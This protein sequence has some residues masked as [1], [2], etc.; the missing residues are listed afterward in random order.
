[1]K[2]PKFLAF[3]KNPLDLYEQLRGERLQRDSY[4]FAV[5][6]LLSAGG[7]VHGFI[8]T[9]ST[10]LSSTDYFLHAYQAAHALKTGSTDYVDTSQ[11]ALY[12]VSVFFVGEMCGALVMS[13][14]ADTFGRRATLL[15]S[16]LA[17]LLLSTWYVLAS[18]ATMVMAKFCLGLATGA[19]V[20]TAVVYVA[21]IAPCT[22]RG[23]LLALL[24]LQM[25]LGTLLATLLHGALIHELL[26]PWISATVFEALWRSAT[27]VLLV[28][29]LAVQSAMLCF[30]PE[31]PRW[32]LAKKTP[33][34]TVPPPC[35]ARLRR[36]HAAPLPRCATACSASLQHY[37][38]LPDVKK[39]FT[40]MYRALSS[41]ARLGDSLVELVVSRSVKL[42]WCLG[43]GL[44]LLGPALGV[45]L[46]TWLFAQEVLASVG[47]SVAVVQL[48]LLAL[49]ACRCAVAAFAVG[50]FDGAASSA[51]PPTSSTSAAQLQRSP[52]DVELRVRRPADNAAADEASDEGAAVDVGDAVVCARLRAAGDAAARA[53]RS[54]AGVV[55]GSCAPWLRWRPG[56]RSNLLAGLLLLAGGLAALFLALVLPDAAAGHP[57]R[58]TRPPPA[59]RVAAATVVVTA[60]DALRWSRRLEAAAALRPLALRNGSVAADPDDD[61]DDGDA[62]A[63]GGAADGTVAPPPPPPV[64][65]ED[66]DGYNGDD[67]DGG[68]GSLVASDAA[69]LFLPST[70]IRLLF[71]AALLSVAAGGALS[72]ASV[73]WVFSGDVFPYRARAKCTAVTSA[74]HFG[75]TALALQLWRRGLLLGVVPRGVAAPLRA[76]LRPDGWLAS[77]RALSLATAA[78]FVAALCAAAAAF[79]LVPE[80]AALM[81]EDMEALFRVDPRGVCCGCC[82]R[83]DAAAAPLGLCGLCGGPPR[84]PRARTA[85]SWWRALFAHPFSDPVAAYAAAATD[86]AALRTAEAEPQGWLGLRRVPPHIFARSTTTLRYALDPSPAADGAATVAVAAPPPLPPVAMRPLR[87]QPSPPVTAAPSALGGYGASLSSLFSPPYALPTPVAL[88]STPAKAAGGFGG[89]GALELTPALGRRGPAAATER[90]LDGADDDGDGDDDVL[91]YE[92]SRLHKYSREM[93][94]TRF[95]HVRLLPPST[96]TAADAA[97]FATPPPSRHAPPSAAAPFFLSPSA[98]TRYSER[99]PHRQLFADDDAIDER[100][101][102]A[103]RSAQDEED[104]AFFGDGDYGDPD[105]HDFV[106]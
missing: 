82:P 60:P 16:S 5:A 84:G 10:Y 31:T 7:F 23:S 58:L 88:V 4:L 63:T 27:F 72:T 33:T 40:E 3:L 38:R 62:S 59:P 93:Q 56:R 103:F 70:A 78:L 100:A 2:L 15:V 46:L 77:R 44:Q 53:A 85:P 24:P 21:E 12:F 36:P 49:S 86:E 35:A 95:H 6:L 32:L 75:G 17:V 69:S 99:T 51:S 14:F 54:T 79:A 92:P 19:S 45:D 97:P 104:E 106:A 101:L 65:A 74:A 48:C 9:Q 102:F 87:A 89:Y 61:D 91:V 30:I 42:R 71:V 94:Q 25:T 18:S 20:A 68:D 50:H 41:D 73:A 11:Y 96:P 28:F 47:L 80:T 66:D 22:Q 13:P 55:A 1:M 8:V 64:A 52:V 83:P 105:V 34:G 43:V 29:V 26:L 90:P 39:E 57:P 81:L 76:L 37:R 67:G 98:A